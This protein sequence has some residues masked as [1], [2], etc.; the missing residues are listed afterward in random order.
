MGLL[1]TGRSVIILKSSILMHSNILG[2]NVKVVN[3]DSKHKSG[4]FSVNVKKGANTL[5]IKNLAEKSVKVKIKVTAKNGKLIK[6]NTSSNNSGSSSNNSSSNSN[7][8]SSN[9]NSS[10]NNS[11]SNNSSSSGKN[12]SSNSNK[13]TSSSDTTKKDDSKKDTTKKDKD[14]GSKKDKDTSASEIP[15]IPDEFIAPEDDYDTD[16]MEP[17]GLVWE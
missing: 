11:S 17:S 3:L 4:K 13:N 6:Y 5:Y 14:T 15:E 2:W 10:S 8:S 12:T 9:N 16:N 1:N 7:S